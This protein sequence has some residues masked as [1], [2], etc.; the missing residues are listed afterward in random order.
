MKEKKNKNASVITG[1]SITGKQLDRLPSCS[2]LIKQKRKKN[3]TSIQ[4]NM[5][6]KGV[7]IV[8]GSL[9]YHQA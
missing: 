4:S 5:K 6:H 7:F 3:L 8:G 9:V 2:R 1:V